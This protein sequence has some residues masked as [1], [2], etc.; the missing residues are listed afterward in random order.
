MIKS[1]GIASFYKGLKMALIATIASYG[2]Y[3]FLYRL[4]KNSMFKLLRIK[5][6]T[7]RH[8]ALI[9]AIAGAGSAAFSNP[10]WFINTRLTLKNKESLG[11]TKSSMMGTVRQIYKEEGVQAFYKGVVANMILVLNPIINFVFYEAIKKNFTQK[12]TM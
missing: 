3:F 8:I 2:S 11:T 1:E 4:L 7:K 6:L 10:F 9:T 12:G 5:A